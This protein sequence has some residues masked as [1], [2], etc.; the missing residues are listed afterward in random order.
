MN[1]IINKEIEILWADDEKYSVEQKLE[2]FSRLKESAS[3]KDLPQLL[4]LLKS[5]RNNFWTRELLSE[6]VSQLGGSECLP[7]LFEALFLNEQ[8]GHD[9]DSFRLF[10]TE[11]AESEPEKCKEQLMLLL[12]KPDFKNKKDAEWLLQFCK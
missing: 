9:N 4:E 3:E 12:S 7:E 10:L 1:E 11:I 2:A 5:D 6:P 8:E